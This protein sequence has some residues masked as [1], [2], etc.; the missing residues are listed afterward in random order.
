MTAYVIT[1]PGTFIREASSTDRAELV[2]R[3]RPVDASRSDLGEAEDLDLLKVNDD[4][5]FCLRLEVEAANQKT[6]EGTALSLAA[7]AL[8]GSGFSER[9]APLGPPAVTGIDSGV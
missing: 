3:L 1:V 2:R 4:G 5:T 8:E 9:D 7:A 6:A